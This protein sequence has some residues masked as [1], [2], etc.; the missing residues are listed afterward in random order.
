MSL[1][2]GIGTGSLCYCAFIHIKC[3]LA[4]LLPTHTV[5]CNYCATLCSWLF[6]IISN[7]L[8]IT[9]KTFHFMIFNKL[10]T[11]IPNITLQHRSLRNSACHLSALQKRILLCLLFY[12][13]LVPHRRT[14]SPVTIMKVSMNPSSVRQIAPLHMLGDFFRMT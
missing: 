7:N 12:G 11:S 10:F 4:V 13:Q 1:S 5:A 9:S 2:C 14:F 6:L 8:I 3:H